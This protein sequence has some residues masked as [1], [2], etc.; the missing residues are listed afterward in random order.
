[1]DNGIDERPVRVLHIINRLNIGGPTIYTTLLA[2]GFTQRGYEVQVI[3]GASTATEGDMGYFAA[4]YGV[5]PHIIPELGGVFTPFDDLRALRAIRNYI[6]EYQPDVVHT[7]TSKAGFIGRVAAYYEG[8]PV[9]VHTY[10]NHAFAGIYN[11]VTTWVFIQVERIVARMTDVLLTLS[12]TLRRELVEQYHITRRGHIT[13]LPLGLD[14]NAFAQISRKQGF[15]R[16][17]W[18]IPDSA[19]LIGIIGRL[20]PVK[21]HKLFLQA[22]LR[23]ARDLPDAKFVIIGDGD[24]RE[25]LETLVDDYQLGDAVIFTGWQSNLS[26]IYSDLDVSVVS[27]HHEEMPVS[28]IESLAAGCPVVATEVGGVPDLLNGGRLGTL[29]TPDDP[30]ALATAIISMVQSPPDI[31][32]AQQ[33]MLSTYSMNQ[34]VNDMDSLYRGLLAKKRR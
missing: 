20:V 27:S 2:Y 9:I 29:V 19:P 8:V 28:V 13:V 23:I 33:T 1:M 32:E 3:C 31:H 25:A 12:E 10:H 17:E 22:A 18:N 24:E 14:L 30:H 11:P 7:H 26:A 21:N 15:F 16:A 34:L 5:K 6:R 4:Q